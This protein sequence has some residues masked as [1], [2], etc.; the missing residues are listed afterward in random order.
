MKADLAIIGGG[1]AGIFAA[2]NCKIKQPNLNV[3]VLEKSNQLLSK[4]KI[5]GGGRCNVTHHC[6]EPQELVKFYPRGHREL[7]SVFTRFNPTHTIQWFEKQGVRLKVEA[8]GRMFPITDNS[9]T[10][11]DCFLNLC[12]QLNIQIISQCGVNEI[13]KESNQFVLNSEKGLFHAKQ[14]IIA[15]GSSKHMWEHIAALGHRIIDPVPSLFTFKIKD[16]LIADLMGLSFPIS[17]VELLMNKLQLKTFQ[18]KS[19]DVIQSGPM[20]ITHWGM[21]GPAILKLSSV[22]APLLHHLNY[23][24]SIRVNFI[25]QTVNEAVETLNRLKKE[26]S[27]KSIVKLPAFG[28]PVRFWENV[29]KVSEIKPEMNWADVSSKSILAIANTVSAYE[30]KVD[31]KSTFKDEFVTAGGVDLK[32]IDFKTMGSKLIPNLYFAGEVINVDALT[33]GFNFQAAWSEAW[34]ISEVIGAS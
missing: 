11:I 29:L 20:L 7:L 18:L 30:M 8:D 14:L 26:H 19:G 31:G 32:E 16:P 21:S 3:L 9:Q 10:I 12:Q 25:N 22:A 5:S 33:G 28:L 1:A 24:F 4:V 34:V 15:S 27:K 2:I 13:V 23:R 6:F 17:S